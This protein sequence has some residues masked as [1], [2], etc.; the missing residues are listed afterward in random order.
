MA[1]KS[2]KIQFDIVAVLG[3]L[4]L[5]SHEH[6]FWVAALL[7]A[8]IDIPDF[9][10]PFRSIATSLKTLARQEGTGNLIDTDSNSPHTAVPDQRPD[11]KG[12]GHA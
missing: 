9:V 8:F 3:L 1:R 11:A 6:F 4:G 5:L 2:K 7:L 12:S 10:T